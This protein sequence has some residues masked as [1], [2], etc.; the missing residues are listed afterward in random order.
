MKIINATPHAI[1]LNNGTKFE[2]S[3]I[4]ARVSAKLELETI[5]DG[6]H[7]FRQTFGKVEG[8]PE[9]TDGTVYIVS[10]MV[11]NAVDRDDCVAP[12]TGHKDVIRSEAGQI[13]SVPGFVTK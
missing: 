7:L 6:I 4:V 13:V 9:E 5:V 8:L 11:L 3:G 2:P 1:L 10:A 12:A